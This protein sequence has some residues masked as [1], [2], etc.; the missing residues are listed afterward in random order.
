MAT[1][2]IERF[3]ARDP[4]LLFIEFYGLNL[5]M[6]KIISCKE[7]SDSRSGFTKQAPFL[8]A[9]IISLTLQA[10]LLFV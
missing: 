7:V 3:R 2:L 9:A 8:T 1:S 6:F 5:D 10:Q 4:G